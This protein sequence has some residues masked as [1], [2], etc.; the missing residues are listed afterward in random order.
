MPQH[1]S[2]SPKR[3]SAKRKSPRKSGSRKRICLLGGGI[4]KLG[5]PNGR[6]YKRSRS[7]IARKLSRKG[8]GV[9][10]N[11]PTPLCADKRVRRVRRSR[12]RS[13]S[14]K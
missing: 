12:K 7:G 4:R 2:K 5:S 14:Q 13:S 8:K 6:C 11:Y 9:A 10:C 3:K 1:K